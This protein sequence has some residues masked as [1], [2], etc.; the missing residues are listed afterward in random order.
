[1]DFE[2]A[3]K[4]SGSR[5]VVLKGEL[6]RLERALGQFMIDLHTSE[7]GYT[8]VA[9]P[10]LVRDDVMFG[11][12]SCRSSGRPVPAPSLHPRGG[13]TRALNRSG[14][15]ALGARWGD[16]RTSRAD[17][18]RLGLAHPDRR[19][20]ADEPRPRSHPLRR[21][22]AAARHR[23]D[24][25]LPRR[26]RRGRQGHARHAAPAPV[27]EMR[28]RLDHDAGAVGRRARAHARLRREVL[29]RLDLPFRV[30]TLCTGDMG[31]ASPRP[32]TSRS[33]CRGR[34]PTARSRAARSAPTSRPGA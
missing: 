25:V 30:V 17:P 1:M 10:L 4:L 2:T 14:D 26:G 5:F 7:H 31:F 18:D 9:P 22:A 34:G 20:L 33:G 23:A 19:S 12:R 16:A 8:E 6:A 27:H 15:G 21:R 11:R 28:A 13:W 3:A 32:T 24:A 29:K